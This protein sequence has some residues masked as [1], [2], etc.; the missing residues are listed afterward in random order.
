MLRF[1]LCLTA[2]LAAAPAWSQ[3]VQTAP[4]A[5]ETPDKAQIDAAMDLLKANNTAVNMTAAIDALLP[6]EAAAIRRQHPSADDAVIG[7]LLGVIR[8]TVASHEDQLLQI[9]A[10]AYARHFTID[11]LHTLSAFYRTGAGKKYI[12]EIPALMKEV[13]PLG[14]SYMQNIITQAVQDAIQN[15]R[16]QG[17]KI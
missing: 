16:S 14:M 17:V 3:E 10:I 13:T 6:V 11:E 8:E 1:T 2:L 15:M 9:Y 12:N 7:K 5:A 4:V